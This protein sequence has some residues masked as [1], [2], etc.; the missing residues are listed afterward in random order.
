M[1]KD[2]NMIHLTLPMAISVLTP[3]HDISRHVND[4]VETNTKTEFICPNNKRLVFKKYTYHHDKYGFKRDFKLYECDDCSECPLKHPCMNF[5]SK[6]NKKVMKNYNWEY[7]KAQINKKLSKT[8]T[9]YS[10]RKIDVASVFRFIKAI[11]S[12]TRMS[13]RGINKDKRELGFELMTLNLR[14]VTAQ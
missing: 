8:K 14:K 2:Y 13:V 6:T 12:S 7:F 1:Y 4:I 5:N 9:I 3:I 11:L 10:Q